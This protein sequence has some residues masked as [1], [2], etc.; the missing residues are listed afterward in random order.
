MRPS[1]DFIF[2][3]RDIAHECWRAG[4]L[5][6]IRA[7]LKASWF[8]WRGRNRVA[9]ESWNRATFAFEALFSPQKAARLPIQMSKVIITIFSWGTVMMC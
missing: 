1:S 2:L 3:V 8:V 7:V 6:R 9:M 4:L 5:L